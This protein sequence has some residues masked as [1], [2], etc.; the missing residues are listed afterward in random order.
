MVLE[1]RVTEAANK[2]RPPSPLYDS[3]NSPELSVF[4]ITRVIARFEPLDWEAEWLSVRSALLLV[5]LERS[6]GLNLFFHSRGNNYF[7][8][9]D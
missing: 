4:I 5:S 8:Q 7:G 2:D 6:R 3:T 9:F 1:L